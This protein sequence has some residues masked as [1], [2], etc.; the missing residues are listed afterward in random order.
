[1][2]ISRAAAASG[3]ITGALAHTG[4]TVGLYSVTPATRPTAYTQTYATADK[5][6]ADPTATSVATTAAATLQFGYAEAQ[7]N[8]IPVAINALIVDLADLK[9][10]V[11]SLIDDLQTLGIA[12]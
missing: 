4:T 6:H 12:Q 9:Q 11:N 3:D 2:G 8:A 1:M 7:A 5:T 10:L